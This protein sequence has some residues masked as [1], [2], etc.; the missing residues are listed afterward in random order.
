MGDR[1]MSGFDIMSSYQSFL[2][3]STS[4]GPVLSS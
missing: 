1:M 2:S 4:Y 3:G